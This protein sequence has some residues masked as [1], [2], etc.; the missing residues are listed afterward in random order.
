MVHDINLW[1]FVATTD[2]KWKDGGLSVSLC[3]RKQCSC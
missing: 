1:C 2:V 3:F